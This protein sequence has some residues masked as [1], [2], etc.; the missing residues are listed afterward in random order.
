MAGACD[1]NPKFDAQREQAKP[2]T[3]MNSSKAS[4]V[5]STDLPKPKPSYETPKY[6]ICCFGIL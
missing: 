5:A 2:M 1:W 3:E 4:D 6:A